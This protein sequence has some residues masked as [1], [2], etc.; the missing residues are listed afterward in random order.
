MAQTIAV[1]RGTASLTGDGA[2]RTTLFTLSSG[3]ATRVIL[4][5]VAIRGSTAQTR[6]MRAIFCI[7]VNGAGNYLPVMMGGGNFQQQ[8]YFAL[9]PNGA[10]APM[11]N[12][13]AYVGTTSGSIWGSQGYQLVGDSQNG[14]GSSA[15]DIKIQ[16]AADQQQSGSSTPMSIVPAQFWMANGDSLQ[17]IYYNYDSY[18]A[19]VVYH[20]ITV[21][22]S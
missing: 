2:T 17:V 21:T 14:Y 12:T 15:N 8:R 18:A 3:I 20:F 16:M 7:D 13:P 19:T 22:E 4:A 6:N 9:F 1:Q 10:S 5:G 11:A